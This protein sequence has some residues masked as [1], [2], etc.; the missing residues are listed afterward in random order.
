MT[1]IN[2]TRPQKLCNRRGEPDTLKE[3][4]EMFSP[5]HPG[6]CINAVRFAVSPTQGKAV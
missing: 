3:G 4:A 5:L 2:V 1:G 6:V